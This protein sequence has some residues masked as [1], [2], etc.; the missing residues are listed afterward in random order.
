MKFTN[1]QLEDLEDMNIGFEKDF[2]I[3]LTTFDLETVNNVD[4]IISLIIN[5][6]GLEES[7]TC[8][9]QIAYYTLKRVIRDTGIYDTPEWNAKIPLS[10]IFPREN[11]RETVNKLGN[12]LGFRLNILGA[13]SIVINSLLILSAI[14]FIFLFINLV[15]G[16]S[17]MVLGIYLIYLS[18]KIG[19]ELKLNTIGDLSRYVTDRYYLKIRKDNTINKLE[20]RRFLENKFVDCMAIE[21]ETLFGMTIT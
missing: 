11:R 8:I 10:E 7:Q 15:L 6:I 9:T 21:K 13:K 5:R 12:E 4:D 14:S 3:E 19:K 18:V 1:Y 2:S 16:I 17:G 20:L